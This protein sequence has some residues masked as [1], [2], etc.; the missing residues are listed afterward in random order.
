MKQ[1][2]KDNKDS[3]KEALE[4]IVNYNLLLIDIEFKMRL[5]DMICQR[6]ILLKDFKERHLGPKIHDL[7][8]KVPDHVSDQAV[9]KKDTLKNK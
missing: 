6:D 8:D 2:L 9:A 3:D 4:K 5:V 7:V 1:Y